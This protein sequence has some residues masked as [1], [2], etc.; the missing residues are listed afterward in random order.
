M[1]L[2]ALKERPFDVL[3]HPSLGLGEEKLRNI[4]E[5]W[6][7]ERI[8]YESMSDAEKEAYDNRK[9]LQS[10][11]EKEKQA[12][13]AKELEQK[14]QLEAKWQKHWHEQI[15]SALEK[16]P[17][18]K[19]PA[20]VKR[21]AYYLAQSIKQGIKMEAKDVIPMVKADYENDLKSI[22]GGL[23]EEEVYSTLGPEIVKKLRK[24]DV[25]KVKGKIKNKAEGKGSQ[26]KAPSM[27]DSRLRKP[28]SIE[29]FRERNRRI[30]TGQ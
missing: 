19:T 2:R 17:L 14:K 9:K 21:M 7:Y 24:Q 13:A 3:S 1:V 30:A 15:I 27:M 23:P 22:L 18:P 28:M 12:E 11:E 6:L 5:N 8:K 29:E 10:Y 4:A 25:Q 16:S 26:G 20:T